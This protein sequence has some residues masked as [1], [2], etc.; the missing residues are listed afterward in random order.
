MIIQ[1]QQGLGDA[2]YAQPVIKELAKTR[3]V[4]V[5][6]SWVDVFKHLANVTTTSI[7]GNLPF[8]ADLKL[9]WFVNYPNAFLQLCKTAKIENLSFDL[10]TPKFRMPIFN[11]KKKI[12]VIKAPYVPSYYNTNNV[13]YKSFAANIQEAQRFIDTNKNDFYFISTGNQGTKY[14]DALKGIDLD[15]NNKLSLPGFLDLCRQA[16]TIVTQLGHLVAIAC[17]FRKNLRVLRSNLDRP[18]LFE[19]RLAACVIPDTCKLI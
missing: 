15:L 2:I 1:I 13:D 16:D 11:T 6:T 7:S 9:Y 14:I 19:K 10:D 3:R 18:Q 5:Q 12:C 17:A 4:L 8:Q